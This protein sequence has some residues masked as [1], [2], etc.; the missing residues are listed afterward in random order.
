MST[1][2]AEV[3][4]GTSLD[5]AAGR[6]AR[7]THPVTELDRYRYLLLMRFLL[8]NLTGFGLL[9]A[10][11]MQGWIAQILAADDTNICKLIFALFMVGLVWSGQKV[12]LLSRELNTLQRGPSGEPSKVADFMTAIAGK[13][14]HTRTALGATLR[15]KLAHRIA[16]IRQIASMLVLLGLIGTIIGFVI[17]LSGVNQDA[18]AD[19]SA[20]GPMVA[21]LLHGMAMALFKTL[22]GSVLNLWLM[23]DYRLLEGGAVHVIAHAIEEGERH[24]TA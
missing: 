10:A 4:A 9:F 22:V 15:L 20:I 24:A 3:L 14:G 17:A 19:P 6:R 18:V 5:A 12:W 23:V 8:I 11:W 21:T 16:P 13:D 2:A 1:L 7:A